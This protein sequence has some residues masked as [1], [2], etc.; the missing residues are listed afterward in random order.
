MQCMITA[1]HIKYSGEGKRRGGQLRGEGNKIEGRSSSE[2]KIIEGKGV[3]SFTD[4][5]Y[6]AGQHEIVQ[7]KGFSGAPDDSSSRYIRT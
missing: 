4:L 1:L 5:K 7:K 3:D 2:G 6:G